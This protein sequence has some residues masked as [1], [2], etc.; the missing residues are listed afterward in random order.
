MGRTG[1]ALLLVLLLAGSA[2]ALEP[3]EILLI[4]NGNAQTSRDLAQYY[5]EK[6]HI[7]AG[8]IVSLDVNSRE[9]I[10]QVEY[11]EKIAQPVRKF[12]EKNDPEHHIKCLLTF[13]GLPIRINNRLISTEQKEELEKIQAELKLVEPRTLTLVE[14][15]EALTKKL[16][17]RYRPPTDLKVLAALTI[18]SDRAVGHLLAQLN[19]TPDPA[20]RRAVLEKLFE[21]LDPLAGP[22]G[23]LQRAMFKDLPLPATAPTTSPSTRPATDAA[24][25]P[26]APA[27]AE[28][29]A[30]TTQ[31]DELTDRRAALIEA[32][33]RVNKT[34]NEIATLANHQDNPAA[35]VQIRNLARDELGLLAYGRVL[36]QQAELIIADETG[37]AVDNELALVL[38]GDDYPLYRWIESPLYYRN[39]V[40]LAAMPPVM[41]VMRLDAPQEGTIS[42]II[43]ASIAAETKGLGGKIVIDSQG[44]PEK[45]ADGSLNAYGEYDQTLRNL[46]KLLKEKASLPIVFDDQHAVLRPGSV[47]DVG[48][49]VGWYAVRNYIPS[50]VFRPGAVGYHVASLEMISLKS[51][52]ERGWVA[53]LLN[54]GIAATLGAVAEPYLH[55][56]PK[57]DEFFPLLLTGKLTLA[58]VYWRTN[59]LVSWQMSMIGDPLYTPFKNNPALKEEDLPPDLRSALH[60]A[61]ATTRPTHG[62]ALRK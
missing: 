37:A 43:N 9:D 57:A 34:S 46:A 6:R 59:P 19:R 51:A 12:L 22:S 27:D 11:R 33:Q 31:P 17:P 18:R 29:S 25:A 52:G 28:A 2:R 40:R 20:V 14:D 44:S 36:S 30:P 7:P 8:N 4:V 23:R 24:T 60:S 1:M 35:R 10:S 58:E 3:S 45:N 53:G 54:D 16:D 56:F 42:Q 13:I 49:Y 21:D 5:A 50:C 41:M 48:V 26:A 62:S 32:Q 38:W 47:K 61:T 39:A 55:S 15:L